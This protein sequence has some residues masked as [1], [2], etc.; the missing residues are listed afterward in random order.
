LNN[1]A[2]SAE[3][4]LPERQ[5]D[6]ERLRVPGYLCRAALTFLCTYG[7]SVFLCDAL[8]LG[9]ARTKQLLLCLVVCAFF[10]VMG[11]SRRFFLGGS[12]I[13]AGAAALWFTLTDK[14]L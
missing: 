7:L 9:I 8:T 12:I 4:V 13:G 10:T 14:P 2:K 1:I 6:S 3:L 11:I 5:P